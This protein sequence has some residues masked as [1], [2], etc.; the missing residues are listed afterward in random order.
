[1]VNRRRFLK[2]TGLIGALVAGAGCTSPQQGDSGSG[3]GPNGGGGGDTNG[4]ETTTSGEGTATRA[5][6]RATD[7]E[8]GG[9]GVTEIAA[10]P[11]GAL[12]F[13]PETVNIPLGGTVTWNFKSPG[14]NVSAKPAASE[15]VE[16][17]QGAE[18]FASYPDGKSYQIVPEGESYSHTFETPGKY[19]YICV[20]HVSSGMIGT[21]KVSQ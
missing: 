3:N 6:D 16:L 5:T 7:T 11:N 19:V 10:G 12:V 2:Q 15:V 20:P 17:P 9:G 14:H 18:P 1:M 4:H 21:V 8:S 13:K